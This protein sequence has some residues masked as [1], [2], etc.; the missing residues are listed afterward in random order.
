[1]IFH[2]DPL[3]LPDLIERTDANG[4]RVII[5][6]LS[7]APSGELTGA[8]RR[9][10]NRA[11]LASVADLRATLATLAATD[12]RT[13]GPLLVTSKVKNESLIAIGPG[14]AGFVVNHPTIRDR[15]AAKTTGSDVRAPAP[16]PLADLRDALVAGLRSEGGDAIAD[17]AAAFLAHLATLESDGLLALNLQVATLETI[18]SCLASFGPESVAS[19]LTTGLRYQRNDPNSRPERYIA[20]VA[21]GVFDER[22]IGLVRNG[23]T[24][25]GIVRKDQP[26]SVSDLPTRPLGEEDF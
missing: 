10:A 9:L 6:L 22:R 18:R 20:A 7:L 25:R 21:Q 8:E 19:A 17:L 26:A 12:G 4:L 24:P 5:A 16:A 1:M 2:L 3:A 23:P 15:S 11:G 13:G 14:L